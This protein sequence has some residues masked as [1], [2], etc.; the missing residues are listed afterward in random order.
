MLTI[1]T[2]AGA[3]ALFIYA[4]LDAASALSGQFCQ[5]GRSNFPA[6]VL[7]DTLGNIGWILEGKFEVYAGQVNWAKDTYLASIGQANRALFSQIGEV[8]KDAFFASIEGGLT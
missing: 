8:I 3:A 4:G 6:K 5:L 7:A 1:L 2:G